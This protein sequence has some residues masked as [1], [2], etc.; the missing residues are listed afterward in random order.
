MPAPRKYP[1]ELRERD[2]R[3]VIEAMAED[4][5]LLS[6]AAV[7]RVGPN[8][9]VVPDTLLGWTNQARIKRWPVT[10]DHDGGVEQG[11]GARAGGQRTK[12]SC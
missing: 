8:V 9:N 4:P 12:A 11:Q 5:E 6:N 2:L 3:L 7:H 1:N 10:R